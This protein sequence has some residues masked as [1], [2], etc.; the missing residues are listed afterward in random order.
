MNRR[1]VFFAGLALLCFITDANV[2]AGD[3]QSRP[4]ENIQERTFKVSTEL[5][6]V[7]VVV[8]DR[9]G[10]PIEDLTKEDFELLENGQPQEISFFSISQV[11]ERQD[12]PAVSNVPS[13]SGSLREQLSAPP[14]RSTRRCCSIPSG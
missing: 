11:E 5:V 12:Q 13:Q 9:D 3:S 8:M 14:A 6:E 1:L 10:Q 2:W 7:R 4:Q